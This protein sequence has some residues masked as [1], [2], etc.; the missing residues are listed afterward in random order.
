MIQGD[1]VLKTVSEKEITEI[2]NKNDFFNF[3]ALELNYG[4][5]NKICFKDE[6]EI[7]TYSDL[8]F[9]AKRNLYYDRVEVIISVIKDVMRLFNEQ[10]GVVV[11]YNE[12]WII[13]KK[14][15]K[16]L[17]DIIAEQKIS[18]EFK[19]GFL[20][21]EPIFVEKVIESILKYN[22]FALFIFDGCIIAPSD[23]MDVFIWFRDVGLKTRLNNILQQYEKNLLKVQDIE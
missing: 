7:V 21:Q 13:D 23:H 6:K 17:W 12:K 22:C 14:K 1:V 2:K 11:K 3:E 19:G 10:C 5:C 4:Y 18:N 9:G 16:N 8:K 20:L 15:S